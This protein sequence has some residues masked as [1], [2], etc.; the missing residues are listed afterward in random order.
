MNFAESK[1]AKTKTIASRIIDRHE[2]GHSSN[3]II[4]VT[5]AKTNFSRKWL[6]IFSAGG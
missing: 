1:I 3:T 4:K 2:N 6:K 5:T